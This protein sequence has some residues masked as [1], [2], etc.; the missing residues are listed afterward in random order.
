MA[1]SLHP[2]DKVI[3]T[4]NNYD[5]NVFNGDIGIIEK[6][7]ESDGLIFIN[8]DGKTIEYD[9]NELDEV[10]LA[11]AVTIHKSQ[12]SEYPVVVMPIAT[13]HY[14]LLFKKPLIHRRYQGEKACCP[15]RTE[16]SH[17]YGRKK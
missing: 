16:K 17:R 9:F 7:D 11:Y 1:L 12:G 8:F 6:V 13:Q 5:K 4:V 14:T 2:G 15:D 10:N 3:Q